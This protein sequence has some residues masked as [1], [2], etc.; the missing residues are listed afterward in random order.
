MEGL[1]KN[2]QKEIELRTD[3]FKK[4]MADYLAVCPPDPG[5]SVCHFWEVAVGVKNLALK[6]YPNLD[7]NLFFVAGF[8]HDL[9]R[10]SITGT[11][12][13]KHNHLAARAVG[14]IIPRT[15]FSK[16]TEKIEKL[17]WG[18]DPQVEGSELIPLIDAQSM[19]VERAMLYYGMAIM[20]NLKSEKKEE[21]EKG[22]KMIEGGFKA[23]E[24]VFFNKMRETFDTAPRNNEEYKDQIE[25]GKAAYLK[26]VKYISE[27]I[28]KEKKNP[29]FLIGEIVKFANEAEKKERRLLEKEFGLDEIKINKILLKFKELK[30]FLVFEK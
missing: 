29:N 18:Y 3:G 30:G 27:S 17:V 15:S 5:H 7:S 21:I 24:K 12:M 6:K 23:V 16:D 22:Q 20:N 28:D 25:L 8:M 11:G 13:E 1:N 19:S 26:V 2:R 10:D 9:D 4:E 14:V